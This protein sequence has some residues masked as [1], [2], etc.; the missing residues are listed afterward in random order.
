[1][2]IHTRTRTQSIKSKVEIE[3]ET[4]LREDVSFVALKVVLCVLEATL[5]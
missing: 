3:K 2:H 1:M 5:A 4:D